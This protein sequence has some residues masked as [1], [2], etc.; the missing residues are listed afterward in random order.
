M[1]VLFATA[2]LSPLASVGGLASAAAGLVAELRRQS[3][4]V[5]VALPDYFGTELADER[6]F[7]LTVPAWAGPASVRVG[8]HPVAGEVHLVRV[9]GIDRPH[10]YLRPDG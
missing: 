8:T 1:Q 4:D 7:D 10:P 2:E 3:V 5:A 6:Q 9:P